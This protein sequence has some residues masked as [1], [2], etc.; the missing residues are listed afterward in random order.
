MD[1]FR[2]IESTTRDTNSLHRTSSSSQRAMNEREWRVDSALVMRQIDKVR[3]TPYR[4][5][6]RIP[7]ERL[8]V[9]KGGMIESSPT[10]KRREFRERLD[11]PKQ[12]Y[13]QGAMS[14]G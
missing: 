13:Q 9:S 10:N 11:Q 2:V 1:G 12:S 14:I 8:K 4:V 3:S 6:F 5:P 7:T